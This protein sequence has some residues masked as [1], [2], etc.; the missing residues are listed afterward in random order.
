MAEKKEVYLVGN[1]RSGYCFNPIR[2]ESEDK[3][4]KHGRKMKRDGYWFDYRVFPIK[5]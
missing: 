4:R 3:T 2:F 5:D 1:T